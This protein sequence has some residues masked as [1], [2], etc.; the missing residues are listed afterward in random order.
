MQPR[1][2]RKLN[3]LS[4]LRRIKWECGLLVSSADRI[5]VWELQAALDDLHNAQATVARYCRPTAAPTSIGL[6]I[7]KPAAGKAGKA[8]LY[9]KWIGQS[10][11][12]TRLHR[13]DPRFTPIAEG[14]RSDWERDL[15]PPSAT[16]PAK[17]SEHENGNGTP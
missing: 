12:A 10:Y 16:G 2:V 11:A 9:A 3:P 14:A 5:L 1:T 15:V 6:R 4:G 7:D 17:A 8:F 13:I